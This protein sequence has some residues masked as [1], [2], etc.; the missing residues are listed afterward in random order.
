MI[1]EEDSSGFLLETN[2]AYEMTMLKRNVPRSPSVEENHISK[3]KLQ[4]ISYSEKS[5]VR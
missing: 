3:G 4:D 1:S 5:V 2:S